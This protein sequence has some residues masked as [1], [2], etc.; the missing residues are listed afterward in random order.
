M[1]VKTSVTL[2]QD[3][4]K[5]IDRVNGNRSAFI[6]QA[7]RAWLAKLARAERDA[8]DARII[9]RFAKRL[10]KEAMDVL[11]YQGLP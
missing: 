3:L 10:N 5:Q 7:A 2:P 8:N 6:E 1:R 11:E 4:L 9:N